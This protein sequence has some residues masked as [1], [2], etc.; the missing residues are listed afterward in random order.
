[1]VVNIGAMLKPFARGRGV[2]SRSQAGFRMA[3]G[4][5]RSPDVSFTRTEFGLSGR[6]YGLLAEGDPGT[7]TF[8]GARDKGFVRSAA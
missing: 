7:L 2:L 4:N 8:Q 6:E 3:T 5:V 1:M